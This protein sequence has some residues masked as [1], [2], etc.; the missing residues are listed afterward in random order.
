MPE[1]L[2]APQDGDRAIAG[3][4]ELGALIGRG[5]MA[6]VYRAHDRRLDRAVAVK[7]FRSH[8]DLPVHQRFDDEA[9]ALARLAHP[10]LVSI[11][12]VGTVDDHPF[13]VMELID[14]TS[15][16]SR[17]LSGPLS[18]E[19]TLRAGGM[20]ADALAHAHER[21]VVHRDIKPANIMLD[22]EGTAHLTDF[23]IALLTGA[24]R[25]TGANQVVG[26]PAYFAPEQ[27]SGEEVGPAADVYA[28][29][30]V[31]LECLTG[32]MA[33]PAGSNLETA[34]AR[35][36]RP[37]RIPVGLPP[38][39]ARL[40]TAMTAID[41]ARRPSAEQCARQLVA[42]PDDDAP[43]SVPEPV[44]WWADDNR[45]VRATAPPAGRPPA[46]VARRSRRP[47]LAASLAG[48]G[49]VAIALVL[50]MTMRPPLTGGPMGGLGHAQSGSSA[51]DGTSQPNS[52]GTGPAPT[53][54]TLVAKQRPA[55][56]TDTT[57]Q[58]AG[59][60]APAS[61]SPT[62]TSS[63][64]T[65]ATPTVT[66]STG[67]PTTASTPPTTPSSTDPPVNGSGVPTP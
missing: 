9:H 32:E 58:A 24:P 5:G 2:D 45:T 26:T 27:L 62:Q 4:Y 29:G 10:G 66:T 13:L 60:S 53:E 41:V 63:V 7:I 59:S 55:V 23:G 14:G 22:R 64:T 28:L 56:A 38:D 39:L 11:Y 44:A 40:L 61:V 35:L 67:V 37:P 1:T 54:E 51:G 6:D 12:D 25:L 8:T 49:A 50:L 19:D 36:N 42:R 18:F 15:V 65:T 57:S 31:L 43:L 20:L 46:P 34:I 17:L 21:G 16:Q 3:R 47:I 52:V 30:L 33:Y 48:I